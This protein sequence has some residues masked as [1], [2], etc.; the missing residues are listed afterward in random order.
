MIVCSIE[1]VRDIT[2]EFV[3]RISDGLRINQR[4]P[5]TRTALLIVFPAAAAA[6]VV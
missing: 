4:K 1:I 5:D 2:V 3:S 6:A